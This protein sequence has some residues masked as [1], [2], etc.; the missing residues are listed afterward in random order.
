MNEKN[1][2]IKCIRCDTKIK[3]F[4]IPSNYNGLSLIG[5]CKK[6]NSIYS[7]QDIPKEVYDT[8]IYDLDNE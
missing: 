6:C 8:F 4:E 7:I 3:F 1:K 5:K 2:I